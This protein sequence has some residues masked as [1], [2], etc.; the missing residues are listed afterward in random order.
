MLKLRDIFWCY[1]LE[2]FELGGIF[3]RSYLRDFADEF[4]LGVWGVRV[5]R[6]SAGRPFLEGFSQ[7]VVPHISIS[8]TAQFWAI[9]SSEHS[10]GLD[11]ELVGRCAGHLVG[12]FAMVGEVEL[13][14]DVF[15]QNPSLWVW[16]A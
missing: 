8:H 13:C 12:K 10:C 4:A 14:V 5:V 2:I 16:C 1:M 15:P 11:I 3:S 9:L 6:D 7:K